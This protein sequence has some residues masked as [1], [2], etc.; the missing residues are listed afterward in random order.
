M[1]WF[2]RA[3]TTPRSAPYWLTS[4]RQ[5]ASAAK[6][7]S[8]FS[9]SWVCQPNTLMSGEP[10]DERHVNCGLGVF[11]PCAL[12]VLVSGEPARDAEV[13]DGQPEVET[14]TLDAQQV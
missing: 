1:S 5:R 10:R 3:T 9:V 6:S 7:G 2:W 11:D 4:L 14:L 12:G 8:R 13:P